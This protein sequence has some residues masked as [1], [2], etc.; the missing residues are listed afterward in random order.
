MKLKRDLKLHIY[1]RKGSTLRMWHREGEQI[2]KKVL[3]ALLRSPVFR[4]EMEKPK[5]K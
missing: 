2:D 1:H 5:Q 3:H 4:H